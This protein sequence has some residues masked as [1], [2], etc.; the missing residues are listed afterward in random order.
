MVF[1][2]FFLPIPVSG[3]CEVIVGKPWNHWEITTPDEDILLE[4]SL[5]TDIVLGFAPSEQ[6]SGTDLQE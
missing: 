1:V 3:F 6:Y 4:G 5:E 2:S